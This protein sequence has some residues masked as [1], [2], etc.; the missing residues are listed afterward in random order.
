MDQFFGGPMV[1]LGGGV[2]VGLIAFAFWKSNPGSV[3]FVLLLTAGSAIYLSPLVIA[4]MRKH[5]NLVAIGALNVLA[6]W[7]FVGWVVALIWALYR[8]PHDPTR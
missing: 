3:A 7:T 1:V 6:G 2:I 5:R 4:G 8:S